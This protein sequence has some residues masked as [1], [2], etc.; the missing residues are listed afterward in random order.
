LV[1]GGGRPRGKASWSSEGKTNRSF[2]SQEG[3]KALWGGTNGVPQGKAAKDD[4][5]GGSNGLRVKG[6]KGGSRKRQT[7]KKHLRKGPRMRRERPRYRE[8]VGAR[9]GKPRVARQQKKENSVTKEKEREKIDSPRKRTP[10]PP[11]GGKTPERKRKKERSAI[12]KGRISPTKK[13]CHFKGKS[14]WHR[15]NHNTEVREGMATLDGKKKGGLF[16]TLIS[17]LSSG[18]KKREPRSY[19]RG[20]GKNWIRKTRRRPWGRR[21]CLLGRERKSG[22]TRATKERRKTRNPE[23]EKERPSSDLQRKASSEVLPGGT[24]SLRKEKQIKERGPIGRRNNRYG[25]RRGFD[26]CKKEGNL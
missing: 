4:A 21:R 12:Q 6:R 8:K 7:D 11:Q 19:R 16:E 5:R 13:G 17:S 20:K 14:P 15:I 3:R 18:G 26:L 2:S 10:P 22:P 9:G 25:L 23:K 1:E 24:S